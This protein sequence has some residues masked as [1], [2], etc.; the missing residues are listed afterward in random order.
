MSGC[1]ETG[2]PLISVVVPVYK[3]EKYLRQCVDSLLRQTCPHMEIILVDD[4]SPDGCGAICDEYAEKNERVAVIHQKNGGVSAARNT[5]VRA[6]RGQY[7]VFVDSDDWVEPN[8]VEELYR[9]VDM[10]DADVGIA[11]EHTKASYIWSGAQ[12]V[13]QLCY[14]RLFD[15]GPCGKI[16]SAGI[17]KNVSFPEGMFFEDLAVVCRMIGSAKSVAAQ[18][19]TR[20]HYRRN[21]EGTM[22]GGDVTRLL[23]EVKAADMMYTYTKALLGKESMAAESRRFSAYAQVLMKL[24][25]DGYEKERAYLWE[26]LCLVRAKVLAD[27]RAR[28]KNRLAAMA[29][30]CGERIMRVLWLASERICAA[31]SAGE[32]KS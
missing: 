6:A 2:K 3:T 16:F 22:N 14:Q 12:A 28:A 20:Y 11:L 18:G 7:I 13:E 23:D 30:Y 26:Y 8:H 24:P 32:M 31:Y 9:M 5:G 19:G 1:T 17:V 29:S 21:P 4:G 10:A 25:M 27:R 15:T